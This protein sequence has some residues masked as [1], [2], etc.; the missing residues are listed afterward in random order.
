MILMI[1]QAFIA[2]HSIIPISAVGALADEDDL[3]AVLEA[4]LEVILSYGLIGDL[5]WQLA[6]LFLGLT[7]AAE[8]VFV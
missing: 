3:L 7:L 8:H 5:F 1:D 4:G 2:G 6:F